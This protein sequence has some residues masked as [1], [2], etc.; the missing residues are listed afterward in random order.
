MLWVTSNSGY[1][2]RLSLIRKTR[3]FPTPS[4]FHNTLPLFCTNKD[5]EL[6][7]TTSTTRVNNS[8]TNSLPHSPTGCN[9]PQLGSLCD[10]Q[11]VWLSLTVQYT[12][13]NN[14]PWGSESNAFFKTTPRG[15][16]GCASKQACFQAFSAI[17]DTEL[18]KHKPTRDSPMWL[19]N[20]NTHQHFRH[21]ISL[22]PDLLNS[23]LVVRHNHAT[24]TSTWITIIS[25]TTSVMWGL[26]IWNGRFKM[27]DGTHD[28]GYR[29]TNTTCL[30]RI[31]SMVKNTGGHN[32]MATRD[33][34][35]TREE[36]SHKLCNCRSS[37]STWEFSGL[38][39]SNTQVVALYPFAHAFFARWVC[40]QHLWL[41]L[42]TSPSLP[43]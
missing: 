4:P 37:P 9:D 33:M 12:C 39:C 15:K 36:K 30:E 22:T 14:M 25:T 5:T 29:F 34:Q 31:P 20:S 3:Y 21:T 13:C 28:T 10:H 2:T 32:T 38:V 11:S 8:H 26:E 19:G 35:Y 1:I 16:L 7:K 17:V 6:P 40:H 18:S 23:I 41:L 27:W 24:L 43:S 42:N